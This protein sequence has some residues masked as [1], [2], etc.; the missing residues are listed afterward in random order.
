MKSLQTNLRELVQKAQNTM[1]AM[2]FM[3]TELMQPQEILMGQNL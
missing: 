1:L 2:V 3:A